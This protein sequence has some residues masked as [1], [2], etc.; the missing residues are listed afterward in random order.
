MSFIGRERVLNDTM[1]PEPAA[2]LANLLERSVPEALPTTWHWSYFNSALPA[3]EVGHDGHERLGV[4]MPPLP[5]TKRMWAGGVVEVLSPL[6]VG[7]PAVKRSRIADVAFKSGKS[8]DLAFVTVVH[9]I[10]QNGPAVR[11]QQ[12]IVYRD[13]TLGETVDAVPE[14]RPRDGFRTV[15]D[16]TLIAYSAITQNGHRIHWDRD[17]CRTVEGYPGLVV[18]GPLLATF[19]ADT[20]VETPRPCRFTYRATAPVFEATPFR[21]VSEGQTAKIERADGQTAMIAEVST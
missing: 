18:H 17:F 20:L 14:A 6:L 15:P 21:I 10:T 19:L 13:R 11:E 3:S 4:F 16:T 7:Q 2:K 8:G 9:E 5:Y 12:T 1:A